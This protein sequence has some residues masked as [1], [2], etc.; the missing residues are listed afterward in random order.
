MG[1]RDWAGLAERVTALEQR[2]QQ[3]EADLAQERQLQR[4]VAELTDIA[5]QL[6][7]PED[8]RD[9]RLVARLE[10]DAQEV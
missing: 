6:M 7:L 4:R 3:L 2:V 9:Q 1:L 5:A 10:D 8:Q